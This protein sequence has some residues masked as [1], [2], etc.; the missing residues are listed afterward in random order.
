MQISYSLQGA[1]LFAAQKYANKQQ[2]VR[3]KYSLWIYLGACFGFAFLWPFLWRVI[4][5]VDT[6]TRGTPLALL[7]SL[8]PLF[9]PLIML[10]IFLKVFRRQK[11]MEWETVGN[12]TRPRTIDLQPD[13]IYSEDENSRSVTSWRAILNV[14][15]GKEHLFLFLDTRSAIILPKRSFASPQEMQNFLQTALSYWGRTRNEP[16]RAPLP[17]PR[18]FA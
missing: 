4:W 18:S 9:L 2:G 7:R 10:F 5:P 17:D 16:V 6:V 1:D 11:N 13:F 3:G 8:V 12:L 15:E 14:V